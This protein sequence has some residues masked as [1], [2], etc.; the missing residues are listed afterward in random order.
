MASWGGAGV[1]H[2]I[3]DGSEGKRPEGLVAHVGTGVG[4]EEGVAARVGKGVGDE[5]G[6]VAR[7]G[8][9]AGGEVGV[10]A[11]VVEASAARRGRSCASWRRRRRGG[12]ILKKLNAVGSVVGTQRTRSSQ[13]A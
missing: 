8:E 12:T 2:W 7:V 4:G 11:R 10:V 5:E 1:P 9:G 13:I 6:V 3:R